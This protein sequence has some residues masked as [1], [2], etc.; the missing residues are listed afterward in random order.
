MA[1]ILDWQCPSI[2][3]KLA[4]ENALVPFLYHQIMKCDEGGLDVNIIDHDISLKIPYGA[5]AKGEQLIIEVGVTLY[6]PFNFSTKKR[7]VSPILWL[8]ILEKVE[9]QKPFVIILPHFIAS[10][11]YQQYDLAFAKADHSLCTEHVSYT[12]KTCDSDVQ[13]TSIKNRHYGILQTRHCCFY[14]LE[15]NYT[16][17][18]VSNAE[19][20]LARIK[21]KPSTDI[22]VYFCV[23][24]LLETCLRVSDS[25]N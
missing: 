25:T 23:I 17:D 2:P 4:K 22:K 18:L 5:I 10:E 19:Y 3:F 15:A 11:K 24:Y 7:P 12:F 1:Q 21:T 14:C 8:C 20:C 6:G 9:L 13:F 16:S